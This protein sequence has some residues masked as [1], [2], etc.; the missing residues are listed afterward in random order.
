[1]IEKRQCVE[2]GRDYIDSVSLNET[3]IKGK[4]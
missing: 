3:Y 2:V 4:K 1:M